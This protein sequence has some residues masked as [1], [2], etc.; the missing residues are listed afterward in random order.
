MTYSYART[1]VTSP[2]NRLSEAHSNLNSAKTSLEQVDAVL[3]GLANELGIESHNPE[4]KRKLG[5]VHNVQRT[6]E[7]LLHE[8]KAAIPALE[9]LQKEFR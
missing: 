1:A 3:K 4:M 9:K 8:A 7:R 6:V 5:D 2:G